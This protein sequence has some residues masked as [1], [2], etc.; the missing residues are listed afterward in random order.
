MQRLTPLLIIGLGGVHE[1]AFDAV[2]AHDG[3][4]LVPGGDSGLLQGLLDGGHV[5]FKDGFETLLFVSD[6]AAQQL[7]PDVVVGY[8]EFEFFYFA[9][10]FVVELAKEVKLYS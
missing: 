10:E 9:G 7:M 6:L 8:F 3:D 4:D 2:G 1:P 5:L